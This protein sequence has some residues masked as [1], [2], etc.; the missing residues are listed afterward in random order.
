MSRI[1]VIGA[2]YVGLTT[3]VCFGS[4]GHEVLVADIEPAKIDG[5]NAGRSPIFEAGL[6][7]MLAGLLESGRLR[8]L[9]GA[10]NAVVGAE[11]VF[12]CLPTPQ[13]NDGSADLSY[14]EAAAAEIAPVLEPGAIVVNKSTVPIGAA[15]LVRELI[16]R[17]DIDVASNPEFLKEGTAIADFLGADRIVIGAPTREVAVRVASLYVGVEAPVIVTDPTSA[18]MIKYASNAFLATKLSF[19]NAVAE[20]CERVGADI[21]DVVNGMGRDRRIGREFL[22][23]GPGF[24]GSCF[25][26]DTSALARIAHG[27]GSEFPLLAATLAINDRQAQ[28]V[29]DKVELLSPGGL[30]GC[31]VGV[32]GLAFKAGTDDLRDSPALAVIELLLGAGV[33][34]VAHD[35]VLTAGSDSEADHRLDVLV[36]AGV[37]LAVDRYEP[38]RDADVL[39]VL[40][41]W[42]DYRELDPDKVAELMSQPAIVDSRN[43]LDR[44]AFQRRGFRFLGTGR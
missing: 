27:A 9:V 19:V 2:G 35:P 5:L 33:S 11:F 36:D 34:V 7:P 15:G 41:E 40:T 24:G 6:E 43:L 23:P 16:D 1:A 10:L 22:R 13:S 12:L 26:K 39:V 20:L 29:V 17:D 14:I 30:D 28:R 8:F 37:R 31:R 25:P 38:A 21:E 4:L 18:E 42:G 32:L 3:A 44:A